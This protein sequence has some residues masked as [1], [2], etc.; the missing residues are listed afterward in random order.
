MWGTAADI[1]RIG[2]TILRT[3]E[4]IEK[5]FQ[6]FLNRLQ[7]IFMPLVRR[8]QIRPVTPIFSAPGLAGQESDLAGPEPIPRNEVKIEVL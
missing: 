5:Y 4:T 2:G 3:E 1:Y 7:I 8:Q 6:P